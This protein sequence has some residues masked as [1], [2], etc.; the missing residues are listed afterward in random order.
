MSQESCSFSSRSRSEIWFPNP[1]DNS[2]RNQTQWPRHS[3]IFP[4]NGSCGTWVKICKYLLILFA[5]FEILVQ[6]RVESCA[7][8]SLLG[9]QWL[10]LCCDKCDEIK[11]P[12][13]DKHVY[14]YMKLR[15]LFV[16]KMAP[17]IK[18]QHSKVHSRIILLLRYFLES[19]SLFENTHLR[20]TST[21]KVFSQFKGF[22]E[23]FFE[24]ICNTRLC[25]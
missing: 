15:C 9:W 18:L 13:D 5:S 8:L 14:H 20:L 2:S 10:I 25:T 16:L 6:N 7:K 22:L 24:A 11:N 23:N 12:I 3:Q 21:K 4:T 19:S 1:K 17:T